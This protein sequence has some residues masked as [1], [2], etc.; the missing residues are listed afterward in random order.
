MLT[1]QQVTKRM[2]EYEGLTQS[3]I[4]VATEDPVTMQR[5]SEA[6]FSHWLRGLRELPPDTVRRIEVG[7]A[8][9]INICHDGFEWPLNWRSPRMVEVIRKY[10]RK[11]EDYLDEV[12]ARQLARDLGS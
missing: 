12:A 10:V 1:P 6:E 8:V 3:A 4:C 9:C 11:H 5:V 2:E 7:L